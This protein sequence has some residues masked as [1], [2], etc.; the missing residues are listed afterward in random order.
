MEQIHATNEDSGLTC[1]AAGEPSGN[2][3]GALTT[4]HGAALASSQ[5]G[6]GRYGGG[7]TGRVRSGAA[8]PVLRRTRTQ[9]SDG[10]RSAG[11]GRPPSQPAALRPAAGPGLHEHSAAACCPDIAGT[12]PDS[13]ASLS[14]Q[15]RRAMALSP[16]P[17]PPGRLLRHRP[18]GRRL[19]EVS[20]WGRSTLT[21][22]RRP[23]PRA[24][25]LRRNCALRLIDS[26]AE[27]WSSHGIG[28]H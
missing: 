14:G 17:S 25:G 18:G 22:A 11:G 21:A 4:C 23:G 8:V 16:S 15:G 28:S 9:S 10:L 24:P 2:T 12:G 19:T 6:Q 7:R 27:S 1:P 26:E 3:P 13:R 5:C 20:S